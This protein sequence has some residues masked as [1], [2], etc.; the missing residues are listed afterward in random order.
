[1]K[2]SDNYNAKYAIWA[3]TPKVSP[4]P[5]MTLPFKFPPQKFNSYEELNEWKKNLIVKIAEEGGVKWIR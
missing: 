3:K 4:L 1:M 5:K 2:I